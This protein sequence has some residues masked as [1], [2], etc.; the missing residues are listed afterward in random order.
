MFFY[1]RYGMDMIVERVTDYNA[2]HWNWVQLGAGK[3]IELNNLKCY[4][5]PISSCLQMGL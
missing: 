5:E 1:K 2:R 4:F 3:G